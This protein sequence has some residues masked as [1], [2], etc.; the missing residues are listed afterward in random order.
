MAETRPRRRP[1]GAGSLRHLDGERWQIVI[2][3]DGQR[4]SRVFSARNKTEAERTA[5]AVRVALMNDVKRTRT[6]EDAEREQRQAWTISQYV[7]YYLTKWASVHLAPT[8]RQRYGSI[9]EHQV[10]PHLGH[11]KMAEVTPS[12]L[13]R[14]YTRLGE[15]G[16]NLRHKDEGLAPHTI[17]HVHT[18]LEALYT[19]AVEVEGDFETNPARKAKPPVGRTPKRTP[20]AVDVHEAERFV[21]LA[22]QEPS[23]YPLVMIPARLGTRRGETLGLRWS[24]VDFEQKT[25][26]V[27][28]SVCQT[29]AGGVQVK[30]TKTKKVRIIPLDDD[31]LT[32][33]RRL[34]TG[35]RKQRMLHGKGWC[36]AA[37]AA[38]DHICTLPDGSVM[39]PF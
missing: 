5:P 35:Q 8:T 9:A 24:D 31:T 19:F 28:R 11:R 13:M 29:V 6:C 34:M 4:H 39:P 32:A 30:S 25:V 10:I 18:F 20:P 37:S 16:A 21:R 3:T 26:T 36:G 12:D 14:L 33:L 2:K 7:P 27:R 15:P 17:W 1:K 38:D 23:V 22:R